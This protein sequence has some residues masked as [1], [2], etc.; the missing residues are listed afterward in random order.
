MSPEPAP[1]PYR[2]IVTELAGLCRARRTGTLF[3]ATTDNQ[4]AWIGLREGEISSLAFRNQRGFEALI[5]LR[6]IVAG[7]IN[8][9][10]AVMDRGPRGDLPMTVDLLAM[11]GT[12][13]PP[14]VVPP[15]PDPAP[16]PSPAPASP[17][18]ASSADAQLT[19]VQA[20]IEAELTEYLGPMATVICRE[21]I[22]RAAAA[23]P[24]HDVRQ[25]VEALARE[26]GDRAKEERFRQQVLARLRE[27]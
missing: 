25:I 22:A 3:I 14:A 15:P 4:S 27:R 21:H 8:F 9:T 13:D 19:R 6:K 2:Q 16:S 1:V 11:L 24:P 18:P 26:I 17:P 20:V 7:R 5:N 10:D 23:S 12:E